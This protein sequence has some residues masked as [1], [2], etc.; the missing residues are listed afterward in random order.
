MALLLLLIL[1]LWLHCF[2]VFLPPLLSLHLYRPIISSLVTT[3]TEE[4]NLSKSYVCY[5]LIRS[6]TRKTSSSSEVTMSVPESTGSTVSMMSVVVVS[7]SSCGRLSAILLT[8]SP[9]RLLLMTK[10]SVCMVV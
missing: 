4:S 7:V 2:D 8:A 3:L 5:L 10:S 6:S 9:V 1:F